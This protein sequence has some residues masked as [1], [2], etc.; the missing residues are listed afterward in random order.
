M[1]SKTRWIVYGAVA[2]IAML[3][4]VVFSRNFWNWPENVLIDVAIYLIVFAA[5]WLLGRLTGRRRTPHEK[6]MRNIT[7]AQR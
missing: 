1:N 5:G 6:N 2:L 7:R 3:L 4:L